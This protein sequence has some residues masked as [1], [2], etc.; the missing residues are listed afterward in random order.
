MINKCDK[1]KQFLNGK[2]SEL[3]QETK[4]S[5]HFYSAKSCFSNILAFAGACM[6]GQ[7][8]SYLLQTEKQQDRIT[9]GKD[10]TW[11]S[12][13]VVNGKSF[14]RCQKSKVSQLIPRIHASPLFWHVRQ[15]AHLDR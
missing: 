10:R 15:P 6:S 3:S 14:A 1:V 2:G 4:A 8:K 12:E 5:K 7:I 11:H 9:A 13:T